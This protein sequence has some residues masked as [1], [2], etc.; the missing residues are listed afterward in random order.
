MLTAHL[1]VS[2][3]NS[4]MFKVARTALTKAE[5][6]RRRYESFIFTLRLPGQD[7]QRGMMT[8]DT[9]KPHM[10]HIDIYNQRSLGQLGVAPERM[11][12]CEIS[13]R[14][15]NMLFADR[16]RKEYEPSPGTIIAQLRL[17]LAKCRLLQL[18][19]NAMSSG[20]HSWQRGWPTWGGASR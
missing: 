1:G 11:N 4:V 13:D 15:Y 20:W 2:V 12:A 19:H 18:S 5:A 8:E 10:R 17:G 14:A 3:N 6:D 16:D 7:Q 9:A